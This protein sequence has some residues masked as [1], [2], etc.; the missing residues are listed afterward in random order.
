MLLNSQFNVDTSINDEQ[1]PPKIQRVE[2]DDTILVREPGLRFPIW[3]HPVN[4]HDEIRRAYI[5][6]GPYQPNYPEFPR[7]KFGIQY[8]RFQSSWFSKFPWLEY[9]PQKDAAL[10]FPCFIFEKKIANRCTLTGEGFINWKV[11]FDAF[12]MHVGGLNSPHSNAVNY[13]DDLMNVDR[14]ID[15][16]MNAQSS[17]DIQ[18]NRLRLMATIESIRWL[19]LQGCA[20]RGHDESI[21]S[22]NHG[23]FIE[24][25]KFERKL[26]GNI[27]DV[28]LE[29]A[30]KN[31]KYTSPLIQKEILHIFGNKVR[32]KIRE[33]VGDAKFCILVDE[34]KNA[35]NREQMVIILRYVD[36]Q[37]FLRV[38]FFHIVH[39]KDTTALTLKKEISDVLTRYNLDIHNMRGQGYDGASNMRGAWN[40][41]QA[42]FLNDCPYAYYIHCFV[43]R[44]QLALVAAA[45]TESSIWLFFSKLTSVVTLVDA[46][47]KRH[48]ELQSAQAIEIEH[49]LDTGEHETGRGA[50]QIGTLH[51]PGTT[52]WSSNFD[53]ICSLV[54]MFTA[55]IKVLEIMFEKGS[56]NSIRR[57]AKGV[58][59]AMKSFEFIFILHLMHRIIGITNLLC[60]ALQH[61]SL[62]IINAMDLVSTT[63]ALLHTLR[64]EG[65]DPLM[66]HVKSVCTQYDFDMPDMSARYK[67]APGHTCQH[68]DVLRV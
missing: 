37:G 36:V 13:C 38:R 42:L 67:I 48:T 53:S 35:S 3:E 12:S 58:L 22:K 1:P 51:R 23:N 27:A 56:S 16:V 68:K 61:K 63:K 52:R 18:K 46:S 26:D 47:P 39:I 44:L 4:Q 5:K 19:T 31:A 45:E 10:C 33:E 55:T 15:K 28:V 17:E 54:D 40:G 65:F 25:I 30:P 24:L 21:D 32:N 14:H 11:V 9:S 8:R 34:A 20:L 64:E 66:M 59:L 6:A 62:D 49:M 43:H 41:L 29:K 2:F 50:N 57:E 7:S 60:R